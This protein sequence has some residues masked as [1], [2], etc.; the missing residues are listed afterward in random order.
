MNET[1][2]VTTHE[3]RPRIVPL[4]QPYEPQVAATLE[5]WMPPGS[6]VEPL[7]LF[8]TLVLHEELAG[9]MRPLGAGILGPAAQVPPVLREVVIHRT[10]ALAN[11]EYEWGV[12]AVA[13]GAMVGFS[14]A[15][16]RSTVHGNH[17]NACWDPAQACAFRLADEL[18]ST[19]TIS[20]ELW[21]ELRG[22]FSDTQVLELIATA[23][24]YHL[25]AYICNGARVER[26]A[27][28][29]RFP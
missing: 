22:H 9:R 29:A 14:E 1:Q 28:A 7:R 23:G 15:Q 16:L 27:W 12:H 13:F 17:T 11:A 24:W 20:D 4:E 26:E 21:S 18:H 25:I 3:P 8:R 10:C 5:R 19:N 6:A 2:T